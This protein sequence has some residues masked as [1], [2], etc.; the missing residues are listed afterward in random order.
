MDIEPACPTSLPGIYID[1]KIGRQM[2]QAPE[3]IDALRKDGNLRGVVILELGTNGSFTEKQL[4]EAL[5][6]L[7]DA[8]E[9]I[10]INTRVPRS[11]E[12]VV[13]ETLAEYMDTADM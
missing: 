9:I 1:G 2:H 10:L 11:W 6:D 5:D 7:T 8:K 3:T 4:T 13:N 12:S